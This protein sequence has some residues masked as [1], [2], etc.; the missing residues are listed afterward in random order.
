[1]KEKNTALLH[2]HINLATEDL[3]VPVSLHEKT[4]YL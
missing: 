4:I 3:R 2:F 1:M